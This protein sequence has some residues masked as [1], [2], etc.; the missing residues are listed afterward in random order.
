MNPTVF[1]Q[2]VNYLNGHNNLGRSVFSYFIDKELEIQVVNWLRPSFADFVE[3]SLI[4]KTYAF[5]FF[6]LHHKFSLVN[7]R[8]INAKLWTWTLKSNCTKNTVR[9]C[10]YLKHPW[11]TFKIVSWSAVQNAKI[12]SVVQNSRTLELFVG[13]GL[14]LKM[15]ILDSR[16]K[17]WDPEIW[18]SNKHSGDSD[19]HQSLRSSS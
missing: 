12:Q 16:I 2:H 13:R 17:T 1:P 18:I 7:I 19:E 6:F 5:F 9:G 3:Y 8:G 10:T 15:Q 11:E 4:S 14:E